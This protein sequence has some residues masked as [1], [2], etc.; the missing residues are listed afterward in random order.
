MDVSR[1]FLLHADRWTA[2]ADVSG[3]RKQVFHRDEV[4]LLVARDLRRELQVDLAAARN[5]ADE[6]A[7][8]VAAQYEG[9]EDLLDGFFKV[10]VR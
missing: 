2:T 1:E 9:L 7:G 10:T 3:E 4:A 8:L 6:V 5:D